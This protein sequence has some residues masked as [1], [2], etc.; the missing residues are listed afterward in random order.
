MQEGQEAWMDLEAQMDLEAL[1]G[2]ED[3][4]TP[5]EDQTPQEG[6]PP[7]ILFPS[8]PQKISNLP[9]YPH[10]YSTATEPMQMPSSGNFKYI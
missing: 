9:G 2:L 7:L 4:E 8:N 5:M 10:C 1:E 3:L 6:Y